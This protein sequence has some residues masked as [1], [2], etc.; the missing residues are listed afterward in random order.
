VG[1]ANGASADPA[2]LLDIVRQLG[3][4]TFVGKN[5]SGAKALDTYKFSY[6]IA[7]DG[8]VKS[9]Q[10]TG[11]IAVHH[12]SNLIAEITMQ[13][14]VTGANPRIADSGQFTFKTLLAFSDYG[15]PVSVQAPTGAVPQGSKASL[16]TS[17]AVAPGA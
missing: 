4:V 16:A 3:S 9:H 1:P 12:Q 8:S 5:G 2:V 6:G 10:L 11:T 13:T 15:V 17:T 14:T 7:G